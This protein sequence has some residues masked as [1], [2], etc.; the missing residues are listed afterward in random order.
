[1]LVYVGICWYMLLTWAFMA[2]DIERIVATLLLLTGGQRWGVLQ[3]HNYRTQF[4]E[5]RSVGT[6]FKL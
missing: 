5:N 1:M 3:W 2:S 4:C 6:K